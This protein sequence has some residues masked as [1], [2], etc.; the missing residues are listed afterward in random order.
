[1]SETVATALSA[2]TGASSVNVLVYFLRTHVMAAFC[3]LLAGL[4]LLLVVRFLLGTYFLD[5]WLFLLYPI[6]IIINPLY[7]VTQ[8]PF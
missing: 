2:L 5:L 4:L 3:C 7:I 8:N 6:L 1:M